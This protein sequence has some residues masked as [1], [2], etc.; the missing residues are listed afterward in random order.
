MPGD[1]CESTCK[2]EHH[3]LQQYMPVHKLIVYVFLF[4]F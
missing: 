3:S 4:Y 2:L 1:L